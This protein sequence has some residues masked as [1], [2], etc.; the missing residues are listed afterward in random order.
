MYWKREGYL[1]GTSRIP[2]N[3]AVIDP[4][5]EAFSTAPYDDEY[6]AVHNTDENEHPFYNTAM[7]PPSHISSYGGGENVED[8]VPPNIRDN[9]EEMAYQ[10]YTGA[11]GVAGERVKFPEAR[12]EKV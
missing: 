1:P 2:Y 11:G 3:A 5:K 4:D 7:A 6:V 8:Y 9:H 12:Y 10:G